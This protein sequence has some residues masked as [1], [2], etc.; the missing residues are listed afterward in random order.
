[1]SRPIKFQ[2]SG[3]VGVHLLPAKPCSQA[4]VSAQPRSRYEVSFPPHCSSG[5]WLVLPLL[6]V[7][8]GQA[9]P[10]SL[11]GP[12]KGLAFSLQAALF[13]IQYA[14]SQGTPLIWGGNM[15]IKRTCKLSDVLPCS[16]WPCLSG[17]LKVRLRATEFCSSPQG[18]R[19]PRCQPSPP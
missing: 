3:Q 10:P 13:I 19:D 15:Y 14:H 2:P 4:Q 18:L 9:L 6:A 1:M 12:L 16:Q 7:C 17:H 8:P 5:T 11:E